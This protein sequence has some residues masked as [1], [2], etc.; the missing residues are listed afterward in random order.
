M[1]LPFSGRS[2]IYSLLRFHTFLYT[3]YVLPD[4][5]KQHANFFSPSLH[6][7]R[8][9]PF[10]QIFSF[11]EP[12]HSSRPLATFACRFLL[13]PIRRSRVF[14]VFTFHIVRP[15]ERFCLELTGVPYEKRRR[16]RPRM[17]TIASSELVLRIEH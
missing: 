2:L 14:R 7:N 10:N 11:F 3:V 15:A 5:Q 13:F 16:G 4:E 6:F 1:L 8:R 9:S 17:R 12:N